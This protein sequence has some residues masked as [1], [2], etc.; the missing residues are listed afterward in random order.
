MET[1]QA[2]RDGA[3]SDGDG[4]GAGS[5]ADSAGSDVCVVGQ[6]RSRQADSRVDRENGAETWC[7]FMDWLQ[8]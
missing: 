8:R 7:T 3:G 2:V 6:Y 1:A 4:D 5:D